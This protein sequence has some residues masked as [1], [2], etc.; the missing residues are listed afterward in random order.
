MEF[1]L[2]PTMPMDDLTLDNPDPELRLLEVLDSLI[3]T[4]ITDNLLE[5]QSAEKILSDDIDGGLNKYKTHSRFEGE[6]ISLSLAGGPLEGRISRSYSA[7]ADARTTGT[8]A[9]TSGSSGSNSSIETTRQRAYTDRPPLP[10][11]SPPK[12]QQHQRS[13]LYTSRI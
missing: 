9:S 1:S 3:P 12:S 10:L 6:A 7:A 4:N 11:L 13:V 2:I 5:G 8:A